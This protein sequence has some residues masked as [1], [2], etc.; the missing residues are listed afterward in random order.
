MQLRLGAND[1][2]V[3]SPGVYFV[4]EQSAVGGEPSAVQK[5]VIQR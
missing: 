2:S 4:R 1:V 5:I 3:L